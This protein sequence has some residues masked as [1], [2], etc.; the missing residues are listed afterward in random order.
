M[1]PKPFA[2]I[3]IDLQAGIR[4]LSKHATPYSF[5]GVLENNKKLL[6]AFVKRNFF[7]HGKTL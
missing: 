6:G 4:L 3:I 5:D 2:L 7:E 1:N